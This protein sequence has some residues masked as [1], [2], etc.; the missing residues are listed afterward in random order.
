MLFYCKIFSRTLQIC[1]V[2]SVSL[3]FN[4]YFLAMSIVSVIGILSYRNFV[5]NVINLCLLLLLI[6][7]FRQALYNSQLINPR[8]RPDKTKHQQNDVRIKILRKF[9]C[10][11]I[12]Q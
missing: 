10:L 8:V 12:I 3:Y 1:V 5:S 11:N 4:K 2:I 6:I 9:Y 7:K